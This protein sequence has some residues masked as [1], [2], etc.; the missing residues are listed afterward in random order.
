VFISLQHVALYTTA[1]YR[2]DQVAGPA[3][4]SS[5]KL[6]PALAGAD[7]GFHNTGRT[8]RAD[9]HWAAGDP[10]ASRALGHGGKRPLRPILR[11]FY[12]VGLS[13]L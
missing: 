7:F 10:N 4:L 3:L 2:L 13:M 12:F 6:R 11:S 8:A 1:Q 9:G 5:A